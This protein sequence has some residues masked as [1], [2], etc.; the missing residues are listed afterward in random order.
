[1]TNKEMRMVSVELLQETVERLV[2]SGNFTLSEELRAITDGPGV[3]PAMRIAG[4]DALVQ[5]V[6][7]DRVLITK[8][9]LTYLLSLEEKIAKL[10]SQSLGT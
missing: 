2:D 6:P 4:N 3:E 10:T 5:A 8:A 9:Y 1:M 7:N